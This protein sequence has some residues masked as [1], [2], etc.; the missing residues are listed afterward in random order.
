MSIIALAVTIERWRFLKNA[1]SGIYADKQ[2]QELDLTLRLYIIATVGN[3]AS[4]VGQLGTELG[5]M[6]TFAAIGR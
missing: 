3:N 6:L 2:E 4:Y 1:S 5:I